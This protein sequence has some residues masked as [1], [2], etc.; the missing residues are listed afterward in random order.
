MR[1]LSRIRPS[2]ATARAAALVASLPVLV[3]AAAAPARAA[4]ITVTGGATPLPIAAG[5]PLATV[6]TMRPGIAVAFPSADARATVTATAPDG[7][8]EELADCV[9]A[10]TLTQRRLGTPLDYRGPGTYT[11][12][13]VTYPRLPASCTTPTATETVAFAAAATVSVGA[14]TQPAI[15]RGLPARLPLTVSTGAERLEVQAVRAPATVL[16]DGSLRGGSTVF[17]QSPRNLLLLAL[18]EPGAHAVVARI[19]RGTHVS[20]WTAPLIVTALAPFDLTGVTLD[21]RR[22]PRYA[23][24]LRLR[25]AE[26]TGPVALALSRGRDRFRPAGTAQV[27]GRAV[28]VRLRIPRDGAYRLRA[29]YAGTPAAAPGVTTVHL[30]VRGGRLRLF[31][32]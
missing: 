29:T 5:T 21:D 8:T 1:R 32:R 10:A 22:G 31:G 15:A 28:R 19:R 2:R 3:A 26:V 20:A 7:R 23:L 17:R 4:T 18:N 13:V 30:R 9:P 16:P 6:D 24:R 14:P 27:A 25:D 11:V 12:T